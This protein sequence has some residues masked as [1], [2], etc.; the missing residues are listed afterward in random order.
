MRAGFN[1]YELLATGDGQRLECWNNRVVLRPETAAKWPWLHPENL[2]PWH[3][4]YCGNRATGG[5]WQWKSPLSDPSIVHHENLSFL[6]KPTQSKHLGLFPEQAANWD[7]IRET[8]HTTR[9]RNE[10]IKIL[11]LFGY[12]GGATLAAASVGASV[13]HVDA[14]RAMVNWCSENALLSQ[15]RDASIRYIVED[16]VTFLQREIR[17]GKRYDG[18]IMDPPAFGRGKGGEL[19]KLSEHLPFLIDSAQ[20]ALSDTPLFL[21][22]NTYSESIDDLADSMISKR[23][24]RLGGTAALVE[25]GMTGTLDQQ[26]L[27]LGKAHRWKSSF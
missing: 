2:P 10:P 8:I 23:L 11:N 16:A 9:D 17:R 12:T 24:S 15:L 1:G 14:A 22:L 20:E 13:T 5:S 7:W 18:I 27:P 6:I 25:L 4:R 26:W 21:L 19:W 3:G